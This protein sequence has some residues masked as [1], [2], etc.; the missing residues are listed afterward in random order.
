MDLTIRLLEYLL[1]ISIRFRLCPA[2][3]NHGFKWV[4]IIVQSCEKFHHVSPAK[5][6]IPSLINRSKKEFDHDLHLY[7]SKRMTTY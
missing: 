7:G 4:G 3:T 6:T 1:S 5:Y 2:D